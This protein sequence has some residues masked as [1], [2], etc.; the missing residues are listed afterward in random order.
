[1]SKERK[2][3]IVGYAMM[4]TYANEEDQFYDGDC[5][6]LFF[7]SA[8]IYKSKIKIYSIAIWFSVLGKLLLKSDAPK[9]TIGSVKERI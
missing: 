9:F 3:K 6:R 2:E 1:M 7:C 4:R 8:K 5:F